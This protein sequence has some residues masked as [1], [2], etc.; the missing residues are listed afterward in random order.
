MKSFLIERCARRGYSRGFVAAVLASALSFAATATDIEDAMH[1][2]NYQDGRYDNPWAPF[3][4]KYGALLKELFKRNRFR[5]QDFGEVPREDD[6]L[7]AY[8]ALN[9][10]SVSWIGHATMMI[11][12]GQDVVLTDP[13]LS[14]WAL[15][16]KRRTAPAL[17]AAQIPPL[18]FAVVSHNHYDHLDEETVMALPAETL[19][20]VPMGL[21]EWFRERGRDNVVE[22]N[23]WQSHRVG[24]WTAHCVPV[25]HWSRRIGQS[26]NS[27]L[28]CGWMLE[29]PTRRYFFAGDTGYFKGFEQIGAHFGPIDV[30]MLPIGAYYPESFLAYQ[31]MSPPEALQAFQ[32]LR[33]QYMLPMHWGS[34]K[35]TR[36][37]I[38]EPPFSLRRALAHSGMDEARVRTLAIG[39]TWAVPSASD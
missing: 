35:L 29:S 33:A 32:D 6:P 27:T 18:H 20:L 2:D 4:L 34:F 36:E 31:H 25:Q 39:E 17:R 24:G 7:A 3:S 13:H 28:W 14:D 30:A 8:Q 19:W 1:Q 21:A 12:D 26:T 38:A 15:T 16:A 9:A 5:G 22:L 37:P 11:R 23:W 10:D